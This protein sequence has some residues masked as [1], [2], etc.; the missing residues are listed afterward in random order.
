MYQIFMETIGRGAWLTGH[1]DQWTVIDCAGLNPVPSQ[2]QLK[3]LVGLDGQRYQGQKLSTRNIVLTLRINGDAEANREEL[4]Y[5]F[6]QKDWVRFTFITDY[7]EVYIEGYVETV[8]CALFTNSET[9]QV[10]ILCPDPLFREYKKEHVPLAYFE[11]GFEF[12]LAIEPRID[13]PDYGS[14]AIPISG[15]TQVQTAIINNTTQLD[16][17]LEIQIQCTE[18]GFNPTI[19]NN[20]HLRDSESIGF[21]LPNAM[22]VGDEIYINTDPANLQCTYRTANNVETNIMKYLTANSSFIELRP[23]F[24]EMS[25]ASANGNGSITITFQKRYRGV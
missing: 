21:A 22:S 1:E 23:G 17:P 19:T 3:P 10:S 13:N 4:Y 16:I 24:N 11:Y 2:L 5:M 25:Y 18:S 12:P 7:K 8:E 6:P 20:P 15:T 14:D 9:M